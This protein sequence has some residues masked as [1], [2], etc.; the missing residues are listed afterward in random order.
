[1]LNQ[2]IMVCPMTYKHFMERK[3]KF[4]ELLDYLSSKGG[5]NNDN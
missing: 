3:E 4:K 2:V 5:V 1:M